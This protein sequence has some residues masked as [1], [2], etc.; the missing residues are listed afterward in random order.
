MDD[1]TQRT[2]D[3]IFRQINHSSPNL[4]TYA[5]QI[6]PQRRFG[7]AASTK[8]DLPQLQ[9]PDLTIISSEANEDRITVNLIRSQG[10]DVV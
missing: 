2:G 8:S 3:C 4:F 5:L 10:T 1:V 7:L 9:R 6:P